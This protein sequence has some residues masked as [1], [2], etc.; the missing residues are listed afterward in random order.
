MEERKDRI[1][2]SKR[3]YKKTSNFQFS[4]GITSILIDIN[5]CRRE[6]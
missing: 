1:Y 4:E 6:V 3:V 5:Y 2:D